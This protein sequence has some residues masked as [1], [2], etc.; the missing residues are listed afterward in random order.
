MAREVFTNTT[1][2]III[3]IIIIYSSSVLQW[4]GLPT[5]ERLVIQH[6]S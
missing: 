3:I 6:L 1:I 5:C 2:I 4:L